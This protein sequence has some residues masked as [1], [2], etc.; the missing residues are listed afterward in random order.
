MSALK[1]VHDPGLARHLPGGRTVL[2][3]TQHIDTGRDQALRRLSLDVWI[4]PRGGHTTRT[5]APDY[6]RT[7]SV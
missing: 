1:P 5:V 7:P 4:E 6:Q 3:L 2:V